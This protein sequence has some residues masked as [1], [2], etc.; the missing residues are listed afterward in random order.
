MASHLSY[1][2]QT[3]ILNFLLLDPT[4]Q[5]PLHRWQAEGTSQGPFSASASTLHQAW[6]H[7]PGPAGTEHPHDIHPAA[8]GMAWEGGSTIPSPGYLLLRSTE[9]R[10]GDAAVGQPLAGILLLA[11]YILHGQAALEHLHLLLCLQVHL[12]PLLALQQVTL[13]GSL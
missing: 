10:D 12:Q 3:K 6:A 11:K 4:Q 1:S 8:V 7:H 9:V 5:P 2:H 13:Q